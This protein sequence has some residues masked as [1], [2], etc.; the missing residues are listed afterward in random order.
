MTGNELL[1]KLRRLGRAN[2]IPVRYDGKP[3]KGSHGRVYYGSVFTTIKSP[4]KDIGTGLL[5]K[6]LSDL[7]L[8]RDDIS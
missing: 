6:M 4:K 5:N 3:G 8:N 7:G 2:G 1:R